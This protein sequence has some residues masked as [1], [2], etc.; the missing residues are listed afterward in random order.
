MINKAL[1]SALLLV[2]ATP[3]LASPVNLLDFEAR[4]FGSWTV[5]P[6]GS[7]ATYG[8]LQNDIQPGFFSG[9]DA[10]QGRSFEASF[11]VDPATPQQLDRVGF[12]LGL[13]PLEATGDAPDIPVD[14][15]LIDWQGSNRTF[16][17]APINAGLALSHVTGI[18]SEKIWTH[19]RIADG[20]F[21]TAP[22]LVVEEVARA[23]TPRAALLR[24]SVPSHPHPPLVASRPSGYTR[25]HAHSHH[26]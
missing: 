21:S 24:S 22:N 19:Y 2:G 8:A 25:V 16:F 20:S 18:S 4:G 26:Q 10:A 14:Y 13:S 17:S 1:F 12:V 9:P 5:A 3:A 6:D 15:W 7:S 11:R 23:T